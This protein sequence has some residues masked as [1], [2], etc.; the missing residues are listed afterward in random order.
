[1]QYRLHEYLLRANVAPHVSAKVLVLQ[2]DFFPWLETSAD[3]RAGLIF[4][5]R[6][7]E[8]EDE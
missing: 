4:S 5:T 7:S 2:Y 6:Y 1:M 8:T 3:A